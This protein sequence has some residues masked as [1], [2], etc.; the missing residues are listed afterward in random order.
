MRVFRTVTSEN[1][2]ATKNPSVRTSASTASKRTPTSMRIASGQDPTGFPS[3]FSAAEEM[4]IDEFVDGGLVG[5][6][7][8]LELQAHAV[9]AVAPCHAA[10]RIDVPPGARQ[11]E[12]QP[13]LR[14][15]FERA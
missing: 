2:A 15:A 6:I 3:D 10:F 5:G 14:P 4:R 1:S 9:A 13:H 12:P 7:D 11:P 8:F